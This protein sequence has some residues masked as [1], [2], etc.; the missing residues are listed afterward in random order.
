MADEKSFAICILWGL[1]GNFSSKRYEMLSKLL[2]KQ[3]NLPML[4][5]FKGA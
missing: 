4:I 2:T 1:T 3:H 5:D